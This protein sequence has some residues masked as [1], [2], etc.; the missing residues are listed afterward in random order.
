[1]ADN[2][3]GLDF[4]V[5]KL[6]L[7]DNL[8]ILKGIADE[9]VDLIYLDPPFF[10]NR[11]YEIIWGDEGEIRSFQDRWS[12]GID[13]YILWLYER[14]EE[15]YRI[16]K[17]GGSI[18]L[19]CDHHANAYIRVNILDKI[20]GIKNF[21]NE[22]VWNYSGWNKKLK[23]CF[24][25]RYDTIF[26]YSKGNNVKY[27]NGCSIPWASEEE[28]VRV[29]K[30]KVHKDENGNS[31]V[32]SDA[33][34]GKRVK[35]YLKEAMEYGSPVDDV[36]KFDK[37][38][39]SSKER[40]GYPTQK[41]ELLLKRIIES[42]TKEGDIILD[43]FVGGGTTVA[44]ANK[45]NRGWIGIDQSPMAI[46]V[47]EFRL[48]EQADLFSAPY[49]VQ[50]YKYDYD[51]LRYKDAFEFESWIVSQF[52]GIGNKKQRG[53]FGLDGHTK[54][55]TP[56]QVKRQD[57]VGRNVI[58][59]FLSAIQRYD[60]NLFEKNIKNKTPIGYIIAF[61]FGKGAIEE[62]SRLNTEENKI[63]KLVRV[64]EIVP[65]AIKPTIGVHINELSKDSKGTRKIEFVATG[66][67]P[68][69]VEFYSW[70]FAYDVEKKKFK[71]S[72]IRDKIGKQTLT[73]KA[74]TYNI[75]VA[76]VDNDGL[77]NIEVVK[78]KIN[79]G[80]KRV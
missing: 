13:Q 51:T 11:N 2:Q 45:L 5:N 1:M 14:V 21:R 20:F 56:I 4:G 52:G 17:K 37:I 67:S 10:S 49:T 60:K 42:S 22:I 33:G 9:S 6:I 80:V 15:M 39:N 69:G 7:G 16:L 68:A 74:G 8:Q 25:K 38:N 34:G 62:V 65:I 70:D 50:L 66:E 26:F 57:N 55:N 72:V 35:R 30:Q 59:N 24:E 44:V 77:E 71:P 53:D 23:D 64:D 40:I 43:P 58:D 18:F 28:Y 46:K 41:P 48:Q 19:H 73:L 36:W 3:K 54:D 78:L 27:F 76:V 12:G 75:A 32:L 31:Y 47:S 79:G 63:I 29:R 61:T